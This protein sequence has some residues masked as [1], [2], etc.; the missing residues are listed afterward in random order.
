MN[1]QLPFLHLWNFVVRFKES[2]NKNTWLV[3][4]CVGSYQRENF[5]LCRR[6]RN[7]VCESFDTTYA[8]NM[9]NNCIRMFS[10]VFF[11][12][13]RLSLDIEH[14][15]LLLKIYSMYGFRIARHRCTSKNRE[16]HRD[17]LWMAFRLPATQFML[18]SQ[19]KKNANWTLYLAR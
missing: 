6:C 1:A 17:D 7:S 11:F 9:P 14:R 4:A 19:P 18:L 12:S 2:T 8:N 15:K 13:E 5:L 3:C 16:F 10:F